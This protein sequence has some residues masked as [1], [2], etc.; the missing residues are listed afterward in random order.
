M[1]QPYIVFL[2]PNCIS[3]PDVKSCTM[4]PKSISFSLLHLSLSSPSLSLYIYIYIYIRRISLCLCVC[5]HL[6][7]Q[8]CVVQQRKTTTLMYKN[9]IC[10]FSFLFISRNVRMDRVKDLETVE[11]RARA[12][13]HT[14]TRIHRG[15]GAVLR[16]NFSAFLF[17]SLFLRVLYSTT[18]MHRIITF[19]LAFLLWAD[20]RK[21]RI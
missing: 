4:T 9:I 10:I 2:I 16:R 8:A 13:T 21:A 18:S 15:D 20:W 17:R 1:K 7:S 19:L 5:G 12:H 3:V 11:M 14:H 6:L